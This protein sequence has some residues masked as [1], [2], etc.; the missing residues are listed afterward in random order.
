MINS[1]KHKQ[2]V[3]GIAQ[4]GVAAVESAIVM[5]VLVGLSFYSIRDAG[6]KTQ[7]LLEMSASELTEMGGGS[8]STNLD[9]TNGVN[10]CN[11]KKAPL[12]P[13][14]TSLNVPSFP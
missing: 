14:C 6:L 3:P 10:P 5:C 1:V 9:N 11:V 2:S 8:D 12:E 13:N 7:E 4:R